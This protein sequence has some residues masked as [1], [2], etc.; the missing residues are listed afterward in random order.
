M[1][2]RYH[3][4]SSSKSLPISAEQKESRKRDPTFQKPKR[5]ERNCCC[6]IDQLPC[7]IPSHA[8]AAAVTPCE[9][10]RSMA[11]KVSCPS[12]APRHKDHPTPIAPMLTADA[13]CSREELTLIPTESRPAA[14]TDLHIASVRL[15]VH[16]LEANRCA[17]T[18]C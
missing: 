13:I 7:S 11:A 10:R 3:Y 9:G 4:Y 2:S 17:Q 15:H 18:H 6:T 1:F 8:P 16:R 12:P 5:S 14:R